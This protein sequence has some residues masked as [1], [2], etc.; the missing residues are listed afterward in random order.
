MMLLDSKLL[1]AA[2][3]L[4]LAA[5]VAMLLIPARFRL[6]VKI[7]SIFA[8]LATF[9]LCLMVFQKITGSGEFEIQEVI[10]WIPALG[11]SLKLGVDGAAISLMTM[12]SF[13][14]PVAIAISWNEKENFGAAFYALILVIESALLAA[15]AAMDVFVFFVFLLVA[16]VG[17]AM[18]IGS[19][20]SGDKHAAAIKFAIFGTVA[21]AFVAAAIFY[22]AAVCG[23]FDIFE[24]YAHHF[25]IREQLLLFACFT[26]GF[27]FMLPAIGLHSGFVSAVSCAPAPIVVIITGALIKL[28]AWGMWRFAMP[29]F[30][31]G[32]AAYTNVCLVWAVASIAAGSFLM[33]AQTDLKKFFA[34]SCIAQMGIVML[35]QVSLDSQSAL[36]SLILMVS[37]GVAVAGFVAILKMMEGRFGTLE[38]GRL[39]ITVRR[40]PLLSAFMIL[41]S[42]ALVGVPLSGNFY[43]LFLILL[44][45]FQTRTVYSA[46]AIAGMALFAIAFVGMIGRAIFGSPAANKEEDCRDISLSECLCVVPLLILLVVLGL[47]PMT[48]ISKTAKSASSFVNLSERIEMIIP[49]NLPDGN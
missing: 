30:P 4:P 15:F 24:W 21:A 45:S 20:G 18:A 12:T 33:F 38:I 48:L 10:N 9:L 8:T 27:A 32:V 13:I 47:A 23:S 46:I 3:F 5:S 35:G 36:G 40:V 31:A 43:G 26:F 44:G 42:L 19:Y 34:Y 22:C 16:L 14:V 2:I 39:G 41:F 7:W 28:G 17:I 49:E 37:H 1:S 11:I 29:L 6:A 25:Q